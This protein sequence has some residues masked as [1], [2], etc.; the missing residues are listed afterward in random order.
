MDLNTIWFLL[1]IILIMG[2]AVL[3]GFD[4]GVGVLYLFTKDETAKR[5]YLNSIGPVW[6]GNEVWLLTAGGALFAAFPVVYATV[7]SGF[8]IPFMLLL[9]ALIF[10]A[11]SFEFR[12]KVSSPGWKKLWDYFF[13]IG[14]LLPAILFGVAVGN[15]VSG[16]PIDISGMYVGKF[17]QLLNA[18]AILVGLVSLSVFSMHGSIYLM[19]KTEGDIKEKVQ[20]Y[21]NKLWMTTVLLYALT[22]FFTLFEAPFQFNGL[23]NSPLFWILFILLLVSIVL[24]PVFV[25]AQ[26]YFRALIFSSLTII[27]MIG[28]TA[29]SLFPR[30]VPSNIDLDFSLTVYNS[31]SSKTSLT[32][33]LYIALIG[34]PIVIAYTIF[35]YRIFKGKVVITKESY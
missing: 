5:V 3:D 33:M 21:V 12:G 6:D 17:P 10:R 27:S 14:S 29:L 19:I 31:A 1:I 22:S 18:Y 34:M 7:F 16:L 24:I 20:P 13:G 26:K 11:I 2:Y 23:L 35:V 32:A 9:A 25:K 30:I 28:L 4:L 8:Y 15:I